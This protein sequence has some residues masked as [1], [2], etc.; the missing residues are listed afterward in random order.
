MEKLNWKKILIFGLPMIFALSLAITLAACM[1][2]AGKEV[3]DSLFKDENSES[4]ELP[5][6]AVPEE[7][8]SNGLRYS[9]NGDGSCTLT[10][11]GDCKDT[12][13]TV[14]QKSPDGDTVVAVGMSVFLGN[15]AVKGIDLPD[16]LK[17]IGEYAFYDSSIEEICIP[18]GVEDIGEGAFASCRSLTSIP[19]SIFVMK[20][21]IVF[22]VE[23]S[24]LHPRGVYL[25]LLGSSR[26]Q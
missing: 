11:I 26:Y 17:T 6:V 8:Y 5:T 14:P 18:S 4:K 24:L 15:R 3:G 7:N 13:I 25:V 23:M 1:A 16:S 10:G 21:E 20:P 22:K 19:D 12:Y 9:S 2:E